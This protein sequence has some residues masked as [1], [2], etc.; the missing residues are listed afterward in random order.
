MTALLFGGGARRRGSPRPPPHVDTALVGDSLTDESVA[1]DRNLHPF[2]WINGLGA[3]GAQR[4]VAN[5]G[6]NGDTVAQMLARI[7]NSYTAASP[8]LAGLTNL[9][10]T[11][12]RGFANDARAGRS[13]A[14]IASDVNSLISAILTYSEHLVI[15]S[16]TPIGPPD[17]GYATSNSLQ[18]SYGVQ[19][20][21]I[22]AADDRITY[23][24][25][26][27]NTRDGGGAAI[28]AMFTDGVHTSGQ[29]IRQQGVD[30]A[31]AM[32]SLFAAW[33]YSSPLVTDAADVYPTT[34]QLVPNPTMLGT[35]GTAG[36]G[37]VGQVADSWTVASVGGSDTGTCSKVAADV[38]DPNQTAWQR[39]TPTSVV[40]G[41][42]IRLS[43]PFAASLTATAN[44]IDMIFQVRFN[45]LAPNF[46]VFRAYVYTSSAGATDNLD[47]KTGGVTMNDTVVAR[48][49]YRR[50]SGSVMN[51][52]QLRIDAVISNTASGSLGSFDIRCASARQT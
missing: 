15:L 49:A 48:L 16:P 46:S 20:A 3:S 24:D 40:S 25:D 21:A 8:G 42:T 14:T 36:T 19:L 27:I 32:A 37:F 47:L 43:I 7:H 52:P 33:A 30:G 5:A 4:L 18:A 29:G 38:G 2:F 41:S 12:L 23:I 28:A 11:Y 9:G 45:G 35:G 51:F 34:Q 10:V 6:I 50:T 31:A 22:A 39:I 17:A 13:W 1:L 26:N 44:P